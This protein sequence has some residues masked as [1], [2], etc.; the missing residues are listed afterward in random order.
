MPS[1]R[2]R[3]RTVAIDVEGTDGA[4]GT[5]D[6]AQGAGQGE[7]LIEGIR[8]KFKRLWRLCEPKAAQGGIRTRS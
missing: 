8:R 7:F 5:L 4:E 1:R 3:A 2:I 6:L